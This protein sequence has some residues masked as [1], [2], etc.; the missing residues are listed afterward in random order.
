MQEDKPSQQRMTKTPD[1]SNN[2][3]TSS[4]D[5]ESSET[6]TEK[7]NPEES[8]GA[9]GSEDEEYVENEE[10]DI[11]KEEDEDED[12]D[13]V[14]S[15]KQNMPLVHRPKG[16]RFSNRLARVPGHTIPESKNLGSKN[17][18]RQRPSVNT[19][20]ETLVVSDSE[21]ESSS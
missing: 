17:R 11:G 12:E 14:P 18:S 3:A 20:V 13:K 8:D 5:S 9:D 15:L 21:D 2:S 10:D 7:H 6:D 16:S 4:R 19:A 1:G